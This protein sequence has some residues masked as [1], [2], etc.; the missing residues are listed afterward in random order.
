[1]TIDQESASKRGGFGDERYE[2]V[3]FQARVSERF[4]E[5][6][7][8]TGPNQWKVLNA[9]GTIDE[10]HTN[11]KALAEEIIASV[12]QG[13]PIKRLWDLKP[14]DNGAAH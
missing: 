7:T 6:R 14:V 4:E 11:V 12:E 9:V 3:E 8:M 5:I 1:M 13:A 10:V 2:K